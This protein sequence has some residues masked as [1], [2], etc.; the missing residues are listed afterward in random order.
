MQQTEQLLQ[1][2]IAHHQAGRLPEAEACYRAVL[3]RDPRRVDALHFLGVIAH[4]VGKNDLA[5]QLI[6]QAVAACPAIAAFHNNLGT[7][8]R[9]MG[10]LD[11]AIA[12]YRR[13]IELDPT[14]RDAFLNLLGV[15][16]DQGHL[17]EAKA[18]FQ[19]ASR[20]GHDASSRSAAL[21]TLEGNQ[22]HAEG[23]LRGALECHERALAANPQIPQLHWN[24]ALMLLTLGDY[25]E[26]WKEYEWR[27]QCNNFPYQRQPFPQPTW[28]GSDLPGKRLFLDSEGGFGDIIQF[29]RYARLLADRGAY[30]ILGC[31][32]EIKDLLR[33]VDGIHQIITRGDSLPQFDLQLP[34]LTCPLR[35]GTTLETIPNPGPYITVAADRAESFR[36]AIR[37]DAGEKQVG[38]VWAGR[39]MPYP[40]RTC[41]LADCAPLFDVEGVR[42][43]SLQRDDGLAELSQAPKQW[44]IIDHARALRDFCDT[45][46]VI[47]NLDLVITIDSAVAH[48]AG[49][50]GKPTRVLLPLSADWRWGTDRTDCPWYPTMRLFRQT[51]A[52]D[53]RGVTERVAAA[54]R[55]GP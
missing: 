49:A 11:K 54:V 47:A 35:F 40:N 26:G 9:S 24:R 25:A 30:V 15:L 39:S 3:A 52:G 22:L 32:P 45:A 29:V 27:W 19:E 17:P 21:A 5:L 7:V 33:A 4:Q 34:L 50:M 48:L 16:I 2:G 43:H 42:F 10:Q 6:T 53:W 55:D 8:H 1:Q 36:Q 20:L 12:N 44:N 28:D 46:A 18:V 23:R 14:S 37:G 41:P 31:P 13:S 51:T 38:L